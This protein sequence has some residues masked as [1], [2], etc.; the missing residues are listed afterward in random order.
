MLQDSHTQMAT[1]TSAKHATSATHSPSSAATTSEPSS[2]PE[3]ETTRPA[4]DKKQSSHF[5]ALPDEGKARLMEDEKKPHLADVAKKLMKLHELYDSQS[6][7]K[8]GRSLWNSVKK[9]V[10]DEDIKMKLKR[11]LTI[12]LDDVRFF[13]WFFLL[14]IYFFAGLHEILNFEVEMLFSFRHLTSVRPVWKCQAKRI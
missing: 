2:R 10:V 5:L 8:P 11:E 9:M 4:D 13:G 3:S 14:L 12:N 7:L 6:I 1:P